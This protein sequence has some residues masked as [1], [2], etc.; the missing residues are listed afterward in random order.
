MLHIKWPLCI[1]LALVAVVAG[2]KSEDDSD[3]SSSGS[4]VPGVIDANGG[5]NVK[6]NAPNGANYFI[7]KTG[8]FEAACTVASNETVYA[9]KDINCIVEV[10]ELEGAFN[11]IS[12]VMNAPPAMCKYV[13]YYPYVYFGLD[14]GVGPTAATVRFDKNGTFV[15]GTVTGPGYLSDGEVKCNY[16]YKD[17]DCC[18]GSYTKTKI[19]NY[20]SVDPEL[21]QTST[22]TSE[23]WAGKPGNCAVT[24]AEEVQRD[25]TYNL[26]MPIFYF[27]TIGFN[28][29]FVTRKRSII[30]GNSSL[31]YASYYTGTA[32]AAFKLASSF[33]GNPNYQWTCVDDAEETVARIRVQIREWNEVEEFVLGASGN[34]DTT[35]TETDWGSAVN[36]F[37]DWLDIF[38]GGNGFPGIP[39]E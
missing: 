30:D 28:K 24:P 25:E 15:G 16:T 13:N 6:V 3:S 35:G 12:M 8:D 17:Q 14:Y 18:Y 27:S 5:F 36:D 7:H 26:P 31:F 9:N 39:Q 21:P 32:P 19:T 20:L 33:P 22:S 37:R 11:G 23:E 10:E 4:V 2:C 38:S 29:E 34:P 1:L